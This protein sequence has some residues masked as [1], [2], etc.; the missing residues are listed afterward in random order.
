MK[1]LKVHKHTLHVLKN[2][3]PQVRKSI[4]SSASPELIKCLCEI[5]VNM[6]N[7]NVKISKSNKKNLNGYK[8]HLRKLI[9]NRLN[10]KA[11]K[12]LLV[13]KGGFLPVLL[14]ALLSGVIGNLIEHI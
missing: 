1:R 10:I 11:K 4:V 13:Q 14:G 7:G 6:L 3:S 8:N 12:K 9:S 5:C 2:C